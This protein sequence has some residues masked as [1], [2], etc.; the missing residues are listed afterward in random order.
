[1]KKKQLCQLCSRLLTSKCLLM[2]QWLF[3]CMF[4]GLMTVS[5]RTFP[6]K[7]VSIHLEDVS[8]TKALE[9]LQSLNRSVKLVYS[10]KSFPA[11]T[12]VS[13]SSFNESYEQVLQDILLGTGLYYKV[14]DSSLVAI[15]PIPISAYYEEKI[16]GVVKDSLG[17]P[18]E[19]VMVVE[20][21][22]PNAVMTD[23]SGFFEMNVK[24]ENAVLVFTRVGYM[25]Q[26]IPVRGKTDLQVVLQEGVSQLNEVVVIGYGTQKKKDLT[27]SISVVSSSE[28]ESR[29]NVQFGD[30]L[31]GKVAGVQVM[32]SSGQPQSGFYVRIRGTSSITSGSEPLY[33]VDGV[34][35]TSI[36][37][38]NPSDIASFSI[39]KDA[40]AAA[41]Y[42]ASGANGVVLITTK[43]GRNGKTEVSLD[44]YIGFAS[45]R[46]KLSVLNA[47]QYAELMSDMGE[48]LDT[49]EYNANTNWQDQL[50]RHG[51]S[52]NINLSVRGGNATTSFYVS[53]GLV[54]QN[55]IMITNT[56]N[57]ANFKLSIDHSIS[58]IFKVGANVSYNRWRDVDV[59]E[60]YSTSAV[61][62][63]LLG[64]PAI[65][66]Y[67]DDNT[68]FT[69]DPYY[70]DLDNP[71]G[72]ILGNDHHYVNNRFMGNAYVEA[73]VIPDLKLRSMFGYE[74]FNNQYNSYVD[75]YK[76]TEGRDKSGIGI[77]TTGSNA[78]W[79]SENTATYTKSFGAH[80]FD[81]LGGL[82]ATK[83]TT[84]ASS[85]TTHNFANGNIS[86]V[87][88]GSVIDAATATTTQFAT[89]SFMSRLNYNYAEKYYITANLRRD[90]ST[91]FGPDHRWGWFP[92]FSLA[93]RL[94]KEDFFKDVKAVSDLK[95]RG[96]WGKVGNSQISPYSYLGLIS[97][98]SNYVIGDAVVAGYLPT[99]LSNEDLHWEGT[100]QLDLGID[101]SLFN[102]R[103]SFIADYYDKKTVGLLLD[104]PVPASSGY[105]TALKNIGSLR[106]RGFEFSINSKNID[107]KDFS[108]SSEFNISFNRNKVLNVDQGTIYDGEIESRGNSVIIEAGLPLGSFY[109]Y[110]ANGVNSQTGNID[111]EMADTTAGLQTSDA[112]VIGNPNPN[113][114]LGFTNTFTYKN[115][116][117]NIFLQAVEG[118]QILNATRIYTEGMW[119]LRNQTTAVLRR[120]RNVGDVT[121]VPRSDYDNDDAPQANYNSLISSR[122]IEDGSYLRVKSVTLGYSFRPKKK[123]SF[124]S[125]AKLYFTAENLLTFTGYSGYDPEVNAYGS[126]NTVQGVD[127]GSYPQ[128]RN[129]V[130]GLNVT[131]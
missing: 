62:N 107:N 16:K 61:M 31:E 90:A 19:N 81:V 88:G 12:K 4:C 92:A 105:T 79:I 120:W 22:T 129:Y 109:G 53:G 51:L 56:M 60:G 40:S 37:E 100:N 54:K 123:D 28:L 13:V 104:I 44:S 108:W 74:Y 39:L 48:A 41:I 14:V 75:P 32:K 24:D 106:N 131:F 7:K 86:T 115:W 84:D 69:V 63:T 102:D 101:L 5:A 89:V 33:I 126:S 1:M 47:S 18:L 124:W 34:P 65:A 66:L 121:D 59:T 23:S 80:S 29:P 111:Y 70:Q 78:Y 58:K 10:E 11:K 103:I 119:Q 99:S 50:F 73:K 110:V 76:T 27:G 35:T 17:R 85:I 15:V 117:L 67:N 36:S 91:V 8:I 98:G 38:I 30:A 21:G 43:H 122:F 42:G 64:S 49:S 77:L 2:S 68:E 25:R 95:L 87:N 118:N 72:L 9:R 20:Q 113:Y 83:T 94:S 128:A 55:G 130:F 6:Q 116:N 46:K 3:V 112:R 125:S 127:Y 71:L 52:Q 82:I 45:V 26:E 97:A 57:R 93:W 114:T 96:S